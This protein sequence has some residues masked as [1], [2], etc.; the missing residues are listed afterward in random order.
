MC[1]S[2]SAQDGLIAT[3]P[4]IPA[5]RTESRVWRIYGVN[6]MIGAFILVREPLNVQKQS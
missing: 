4:V 6:E 1:I 2:G 3:D 5:S